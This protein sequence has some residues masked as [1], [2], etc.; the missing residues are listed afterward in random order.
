MIITRIP[1]AIAA[2]AALLLAC[3]ERNGPTTPRTPSFDLVNAANAPAPFS[4][5]VFNPC[6]GEN[7][8]IDG[9]IQLR[10]DTRSDANG[11]SHTVGRIFER[12]KGTGEVTGANYVFN[13]D[14]T[15]NVNAEAIQ[16]GVSQIVYIRLIGQGP[17]PNFLGKQVLHFTVNANGDLVGV[18]DDFSGEC[19]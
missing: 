10:F 16:Q 5:V 7:V 4:T 13:T 2:G 1:L 14:S 17:A 3:A 12:G 15:I 18:V 8:D 11:G 9:T 6:N 19:R